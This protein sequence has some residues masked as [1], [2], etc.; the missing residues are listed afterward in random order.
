MK[1]SHSKLNTILTCPMTYYLNYVQGIY[2]KYEKSALGIGSAVH[3]GI[4]HNTEELD[5]YYNSEGS[6]R[7][8]LNYTTD[9]ALAESM[10]HG[11]LGKKDDIIKEFL[12]DDETG[13][14]LDILEENHEITFTAPLKS[15][16]FET[17]HEFLGIIDLLIKTKKGYIVIDY[18]TSS[19]TPDWD[20]YLDQIYRYIFLLKHNYPDIPVY[21]IGIINLKKSSIR[22]RKNETEEEFIIRLKQEYDI[23]N[24]LINSHIYLPSTLDSQLINDYIENLTNMADTAQKI[25]DEKLLFINFGNANGIYGKSEYYD[26]FYKTPD[27]YILYKIKDSIYNEDTGE[28]EEYRDCIPL[29]LETI[30]ISKNILNHYKDFEPLFKQVELDIDALFKLLDFKKY[31]YDKD[32]IIKYINTY[33]FTLQNNN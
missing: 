11:Y 16:L 26:I 7:Q 6:F 1:L 33:L 28:I 17:P 23:N 5:E 30:D 29:D 4:E 15:K 13:E 18:K 10:V 2:S 20:K 22:Q 24:E 25:A 12:L 14:T 27:A 21:K 31:I 3:W 9:H 8:S 19:Q 32:L